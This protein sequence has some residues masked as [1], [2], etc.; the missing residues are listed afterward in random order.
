MPAGTYELR[1]WT[2]NSTNCPYPADASGY[3]TASLIITPSVSSAS[4]L[5]KGNQA[6][7][8]ATLENTDT[9][10]FL[11]VALDLP[12][13]ALDQAATAHAFSSLDF[14]NNSFTLPITIDSNVASDAT[15]ANVPSGDY[16]ATLWTTR[17]NTCPDADGRDR[18]A[19][20][21]VG[22]HITSLTLTSNDAADTV[23]GNITLDNSQ[24]PTDYN[25]LDYRLCYIL[26]GP[27]TRQGGAADSPTS[28]RN[29]L[30][31]SDAIT[32]AANRTFTYPF[33][34]DLAAT[35][36]GN[37]T[38]TAWTAHNTSQTC[39]EGL[40]ANAQTAVARNLTFSRPTVQTLS[41]S[42][43][44]L[45]LTVTGA[46]SAIPEGLSYTGLTGHLCYEI[47]RPDTVSNTWQALPAAS[48]ANVSFTDPATPAQFRSTFERRNTNL[49]DTLPLGQYRLRAW[50]A[51]DSSC[52]GSAGATVATAT[53][54][55]L[56]ADS[57]S[58]TINQKTPTV[59]ATLSNQYLAD[60]YD[61][62]G[63]YLCA[64]LQ[65]PAGSLVGGTPEPFADLTFSQITRQTS[66][67][68]TNLDAVPSGN[69]TATVWTTTQNS[70]VTQASHSTTATH[71][72]G[73][74]VETLALTSDFTAQ[75][76]SAAITFDDS[77]AGESY[78]TL[79]YKLCYQLTDPAGVTTTPPRNKRF[80]SAGLS[81]STERQTTLT[82]T[83][84]QTAGDY[85]LKTW[86]A[87][88]SRL[89]STGDR[90]SPHTKTATV[91]HSEHGDPPAVETL[92]LEVQGNNLKITGTL[93]ALPEGTEYADLPNYLCFNYKFPYTGRA[94]N[95]DSWYG[96][97]T[98]NVSPPLPNP[99]MVAF[100]TIDFPD[101]TS[102][103]VHNAP[104][105]ATG[106]L[107]QVRAWT[108]SDQTCS[109]DPLPSY[110][111]AEDAKPPV[112]RGW[113]PTSWTLDNS[114][115][116]TNWEALNRQGT[117]ADWQDAVDNLTET[118]DYSTLP[119]KFCYA[120]TG[121][122]DFSLQGSKPFSDFTFTRT[123]LNSSGQMRFRYNIYEILPADATGE[124]T[125]TN[126]IAQDDL[127]CLLATNG[128]QRTHMY[129]MENGRYTS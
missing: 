89:C 16:T 11:C 39:A 127:D 111:Q 53:M 50:T 113:G 114:H 120:A 43:V 124:Y 10:T 2:S 74:H 99:N 110:Q 103:F 37:Y 60:S 49:V 63:Y 29:R 58:L 1:G 24:A 67:A 23:T 12:G 20:A 34:D 79:P 97:R 118:T 15:N 65:P 7:L 62:L 61:T 117:R 48:F 76:L 57:A 8:S 69:Y 19:T 56:E 129:D 121:P 4:L 109:F 3:Q 42:S 123:D 14:T 9:G 55:N 80:G 96:W 122:N 72:V 25:T 88:S 5:I 66:Y 115:A 81:I 47:D 94:H 95:S 44:G 59:T 107:Y 128:Y 32:I 92:S 41:F 77:V 35:G 46:F 13:T 28:T 78:N 104:W 54:G 75:T 90:G 87:F 116:P 70:C 36:Q 106:G 45:T 108:S 84:I 68:L 101:N 6:E 102:Q 100:N 93:E 64:T 86:T 38:V 91:T 40:N 73:P 22:P 27:P 126:W 112:A 119:Y 98:Y 26:S 51:P 18:T 125:I 85:T 30:F 71:F 83:G 17:D 105:N 82:L 31:S 52:A 21:T 33:S